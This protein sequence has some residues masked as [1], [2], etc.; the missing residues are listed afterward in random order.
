MNHSVDSSKFC[1]GKERG[2][3]DLFFLAGCQSDSLSLQSGNFIWIYHDVVQ[4]RSMSDRGFALFYR[5]KC[6]FHPLKQLFLE[7]FKYLF[8]FFYSLFWGINCAMVCMSHLSYS[9]SCNL[10][11]QFILVFLP[12]ISHFFL[13][14]IS[15]V[16]VLPQYSSNM[17]FF[18][19]ILF[20]SS[21]FLSLTSQNLFSAIGLINIF[22]FMCYR[23]D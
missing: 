17:L 22:E 23:S 1:H 20:Y 14:I 3:L 9:F 21:S 18:M 13:N 8:Y 6:T 15:V 2:Q 4:F 11:V 16:P 19:V 7:Y 10:Q 12:H 5:F